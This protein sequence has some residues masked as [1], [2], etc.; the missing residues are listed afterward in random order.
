MDGRLSTPHY[1]EK[2]VNRERVFL[3]MMFSQQNPTSKKNNLQVPCSSRTS[4]I[5]VTFVL[6]H[7]GTFIKRQARCVL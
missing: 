4:I 1:H 7:H 6:M 3:S 5:V 2:S